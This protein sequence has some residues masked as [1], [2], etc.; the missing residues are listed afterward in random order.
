MVRSDSEVTVGADDR[1]VNAPVAVHDDAQIKIRELNTAQHI[2]RIGKGLEIEGIGGV[3][4]GSLELF[5]RHNI[6]A[7]VFGNSN[8]TD[9]KIRLIGKADGFV[10]QVLRLKGINRS[11]RAVH[12]DLHAVCHAGEII[13]VILRSDTV[14]STIFQCTGEAFGVC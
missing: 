11:L 8:P 4:K 9:G 2:G 13:E 12:I 3:V 6:G 1:T 14:D 7:V 10:V 5:P